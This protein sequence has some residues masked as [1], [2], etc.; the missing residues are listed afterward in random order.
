MK[1]E[2]VSAACATIC[3]LL[4]LVALVFAVNFGAQDQ[5]TEGLWAFIIG[6]IFLGGSAL[7]KPTIRH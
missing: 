7:F 5:L 3:I 6:A 1:P 4:W 2:T